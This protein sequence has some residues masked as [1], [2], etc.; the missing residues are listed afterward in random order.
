M[1]RA[2]AAPDDR[3]DFV[4]ITV[5]GNDPE[6]QKKKNRTLGMNDGDART[7]RYR[8]WDNLQYWFRAVEKF[9]PWVN[10]VY[11]VTD[12]Q[13]PKWINP[14]CEKLVLVNHDEFIPEKYLPTFSS[15]PI[16]HNLFRIKGLSEKFVYFNDDMFIR[17]PVT[18][19]QFFK[20]GLP[21]DYALEEPMTV[22]DPMFAHIV[23]NNILMLNEHYRRKRVLKEQKKKFYS[24]VYFKGMLQNR[25]L[26]VLKRNVFF[27]FKNTHMPNS[28][29][30]SSFKAV[31]ERNFETL[32]ATCSRKVR[33]HEDVNQ[34]IYVQYQY[35]N[36]LFTPYDWGGTRHLY[37]CNDGNVDRIAKD[38]VRQKYKM[39]CINEADELDFEYAKRKINAAWEE[40]LPEKSS[41]EL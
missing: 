29:L 24:P 12:H 27:G 35:V 40:L 18:P 25:M 31:W 4:I 5:D 36:G 14:D 39:I 6:W 22:H 34:Y 7:I 41:F 20:N 9:A 38:I 10:K 13:A 32:D 30:K 33:R 17:G 28:M 19:D 16:E 21:C 15:H 23:T 2:K 1:S 8:S 3:I 11:L 37:R 26:S